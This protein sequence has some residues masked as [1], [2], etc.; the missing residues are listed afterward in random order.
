VKKTGTPAGPARQRVRKVDA[1]IPARVLEETRKQE[2]QQIL[3]NRKAAFLQ[4]LTKNMGLISKT[5]KDTGTPRKEYEYWFA[6]DLAFRR[7]VE[8]VQARQVDFAEAK[9]FG[10]INEGDTRAI[11]FYL[12]NKGARNGY[13]NTYR[14]D[15]IQEALAS[16]DKE[17]GAVVD[18]RSEIMQD[19]A[20]LDDAAI[21]EAMRI[22]C[23]R[24]PGL[25]AINATPKEPNV[26]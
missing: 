4:G 3:A 22:A 1:G 23:Q 24:V 26:T 8:E 6:A 21:V 13:V 16:P 5:L 15:P 25:F 10:R 2:R 7:E 9:L 20:E 12:S 18:G 14:P 19:R 17:E 11:M